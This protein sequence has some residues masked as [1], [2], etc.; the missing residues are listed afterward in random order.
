MIHTINKR[1]TNGEIKMQD[2]GEVIESI[3]NHLPLDKQNE[4]IYAKYN[5]EGIKPSLESTYIFGTMIEQERVGR[6]FTR[7]IRSRHQPG[8]NQTAFF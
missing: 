6:Q 8:Q 3:C 5:Q 4:G 7:I 1:R 2:Q